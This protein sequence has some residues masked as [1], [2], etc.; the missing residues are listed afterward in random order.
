MTD[1]FQNEKIQIDDVNP[2]SPATMAISPSGSPLARPDG[3]P[4][5][6]GG[7][8]KIDAPAP[9]SEQNTSALPTADAA[10]RVPGMSL[11][12]DDA[13]M[14]TTH[15]VI[16][17]NGNGPPA[18]PKVGEGD[19][20]PQAPELQTPTGPKDIFASEGIAAP[21]PVTIQQTN[22]DALNP[23][24]PPQVQQFV[25]AQQAQNE[26]IASHLF[27]PD[28]IANFKANPISLS[29]IT[30]MGH[31]FDV[32]KVLPG[33]NLAFGT[34]DAIRLQSIQK[35]I[36]G[37]DYQTAMHTLSI[38]DAQLLTDTAKRALEIKMRGFA[39]GFK[40][41]AAEAIFDASSLPAWMIQFAA[42]GA[43]ANVAKGALGLE[44]G[45][46]AMTVGGAA[47]VAPFL[48]TVYSNAADAQF[49]QSLAITDKGQMYLQQAKDSMPHA[50]LK[51]FA[52]T[53]A[54]IASQIYG[55]K[56]VEDVAKVP[57]TGA[58]NALPT[59]VK[60]GI[61]EAYKMINPSAQV[62]KA[63]S[64]FGWQGVLQQ[65]GINRIDQVAHAA[66]NAGTEKDY[67]FHDFVSD[68]MPNGRQLA[69]EAGLLAIPA[70]ISASTHAAVG[71]MTQR[72]VP[73]AQAHDTVQAMSENQR[74]EFVNKNIPLPKS[75]YPA[76]N[77]ETI[78]QAD[79]DAAMGKKSLHV[80]VPVGKSSSA[81]AYINSSPSSEVSAD[82]SAESTAGKILA[83]GTASTN[84]GAEAI[85]GHMANQQAIDPPPIHQD[86][87]FFNK[88]T[89]SKTFK[90]FYGAT[91]N[92]MQPVEDLATKAEKAGAKIPLGQDPRLLI[93]NAKTTMGLIDANIQF[94]RMYHDAETGDL[95][96]G[97]KSLKAIYDDFDNVFSTTE[98][99][100]EQRHT[101]FSDYQSARSQLELAEKRPD[102]YMPEEQKQMWQDRV[103]ELQ[104]KYGKDFPFFETFAKEN[105]EWRNAMYYNHLVRTGLKSEQQYN[106][107]VESREMYAPGYREFPEEEDQKFKPSVNTQNMKKD[108]NANRIGSMKQA[109]GSKREIKNVFMSDV[110][111][112]AQMVQKGE[113]NRLIRSMAN[114]KEVLPE[115]VK[116]SNPK[117][118]ANEVTH[119]Y[120]PVLRQKIEATIAAL[121]GKVERSEKVN[122]DGK[123]AL[124]SYTFN[125]KLVKMKLG[126]TE[127]TLAHEAGHMLDDVLGLKDRM[128]SDPKIKSELQ[129]LSEDRLYRRIDLARDPEG[130]LHFRE[131]VDNSGKG[132]YLDYIK[133]DREILANMFDAYVN[134]P[135]QLK[136]VAPTALK[137]FNKILDENPDL[138]FIKDIKP[139]TSRAEEVIQKPVRDL[140]GPDGSLPFYENG[141]RKFLEVS[142][143]IQKA[144]KGQT[145]VQFESYLKYLDAIG[146]AQKK[147]LQIGA[148]SMPGFM[149]RHPLRGMQLAF[150]N[151]YG[152]ATP[153]DFAK[154]VFQVLGASDR[155]QEWKAASGGLKQFAPIDDA[156]LQK[157]MDKT[158]ATPMEKL[159]SPSH[160]Y[161]SLKSLMDH[162]A[163]L[164]VFNALTR[165]G[166]PENEAALRSLS[167]TLDYSRSGSAVKKIGRYS[168]FLN[169]EMQNIDSMIKSF[170]NNPKGFAIAATTMW[171]IP[172]MLVTGYYLFA[173]DDKT[174]KEYL[175][176]SAERRFLAM[177][178][179]I[180]DHWIPFPRAFT[181]AYIFGSIP[182]QVMI[183]LFNKGG[184]EPANFFGTMATGLIKS[185]G[186][187]GDPTASIPPVIKA[188]IEGKIN[189]NFYFESHLYP[190]YKES[191]PPPARTNNSDT[192]VAKW[193]GE[194]L[195][196]SPAAIDNF[197]QDT[198]GNLGKWITQNFDA[199]GRDI[200]K[201]EGKK[202]S[203]PPSGFENSALSNGVIERKPIGFNSQDVQT[204]YERFDHASEIH[205][206][207]TSLKNEGSEQ[208]AFAKENKGDLR[209][210]E[211]LQ[212]FHK[213]LA[214]MNKEIKAI[215][216]SESLSGD[217]K[218][219]QIDRIGEQM[220]NIAHQAN[221]QY[222]K[223]NGGNHQ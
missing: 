129:T 76:L 62:S 117:I 72:G 95:V 85:Y 115:D 13:Q 5:L 157:Y 41:G 144:F 38:N 113:A 138:Q 116:V 221:I 204:F 186:F 78:S 66:I 61:Y 67:S 40:G 223:S 206:Q 109:L 128:L 181:P 168:P 222:L 27:S 45:A 203:E 51:S 105:R 148:T 96:K 207:F 97:G 185:V 20:L 122:V 213:E 17:M 79:A 50:L 57:L 169:V 119:S 219:K 132:K 125:E 156:A 54:D 71:I 47:R 127:G 199:I 39:P 90:E 6:G 84:N 80:V 167:A 52:Y 137:E 215:R 147:I 111:N 180:A 28:Q 149:L 192:G 171:T 197:I 159:L 208:E 19:V 101:D 160:L 172:Q 42:G 21:A 37:M 145:R 165:D 4:D 87:S 155:Y 124:G 58:I 198:S 98:P 107:A 114:L 46:A 100:M 184:T 70:G 36:Q 196:M 99:D 189:Y 153:L 152:K 12:P 44:T 81:E 151:T 32:D 110:K 166:V 69:I 91:F 178:I 154:A 108:P 74:E 104:E 77:V 14:G 143:E 75:A 131:E 194:K 187:L 34:Y 9:Q 118:I 43:L 53:S 103:A 35:Q 182:E 135:E 64:V 134:A 7:T 22:Q 126:S 216:A 139:S 174:R 158:F 205:N 31:L 120:D 86:N 183:H 210:Y 133:N 220:T 25:Q 188:L 94:Q 146:K 209:N 93:N 68:A 173:A 23:V 190:A 175:E 3:Q 140:K 33:A 55:G 200:D 170:K 56:L 60:Q 121:G 193:L 88:M 136:E 142:P 123:S 59:S 141:K 15:D 1:I 214:G 24:N 26:N 217:A 10:P 48:P 201:A 92:D 179:K 218:Q 30:Q 102:Y 83:D 130:E 16:A 11:S 162:P 82:I 2:A 8:D 49:N 63:L 195:N 65:L 211:Q 164:A 177:N 191:M 18:L 212:N 89:N 163:R 106:E 29:N 112:A 161:S 73:E 202:V 150:V 176:L